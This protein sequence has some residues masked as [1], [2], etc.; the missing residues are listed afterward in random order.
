L[1]DLAELDVKLIVTLS[2]FI[3]PN[4]GNKRYASDQSY[5]SH[6]LRFKMID[7]NESQGA[8]QS[9]VSKAIKDEQDDYVA[10]GSENWILGSQVRDKGS[11]HKDIWV[12]SAADLALRN[13]IA[14]Y[15]VGGWWKNRKKLNR[16]DSSVRYSL[17]ISIETNEADID[18]YNNVL[19]QI[20][21][22]IPIDI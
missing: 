19:N 12:G 13:Q 17:I 16:Y 14:V 3:E 9:R 18:I 15:P 21:V 1:S 22:S 20:K 7:K 6:G 4:P 5:K 11:I 10:E 2:Y 8:F